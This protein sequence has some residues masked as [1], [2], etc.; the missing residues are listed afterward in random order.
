MLP[1]IVL[2]ACVNLP[3][4]ESTVLCPSGT[5]GPDWITSSPPKA[6][7]GVRLCKWWAISKPEMICTV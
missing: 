1:L 3:T 2:F 4:A 7:A 5:P 6:K